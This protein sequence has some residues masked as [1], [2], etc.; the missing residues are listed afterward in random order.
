MP[1]DQIIVVVPVYNHA[2]TLRAVVARTLAVHPRVLVVDDGSTDGG[3]DKLEGLPV[4]ILRHT[5]NLGKGAAILTAA[6][7]AGKLGASHIIT[8]D[9]DGQHDPEEIQKFLSAIATHPR[10]I[11][12]GKRDF[13]SA[14]LPWGRKFG[15]AFS[16]FWL[17]V[18]TGRPIGDAQSG[19]RAYP[20]IVLEALKL[21]DRRF[22]FEIEVLVKASW[23][24]V[25][26]MDI[27]ISVYYPP[28]NERISHFKIFMDN[29]RLTFLNTRLTMRSM[30]PWPHRKIIPR[31]ES[32]K[33]IS[34]L[35]PI[36]AFRTLLTGDNSPKRLAAAGAL[37]V[38]LGALPL[39]AFHIA[40]ILFTAGFL[41]LNKIAAV[42][43]SQ[44]CMPPIVPA[45]CIEAGYF[46]RHGSFLTEVSLETL[47]YQALERIF[48]WFLGSLIVGPAL[49][50]VVWG[51]IYVFGIAIKKDSKDQSQKI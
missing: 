27:D 31:E 36:K 9:A 1:E 19:F 15:R 30:F 51:I 46:M 35:H 41:R 38:F 2:Y 44:L 17:R 32:E 45:I 26:L 25:D 22:S 10:A 4:E 12:V 48:E 3:A 49:A 7:R 50:F 16:N 37:G 6:D 14:H 34:I 40:A 39:I 47:G 24:G 5:K 28:R 33:K 21:R 42:T 23:A 13:E 8:I 43:A 18:Q 20:L 29:L 11:L